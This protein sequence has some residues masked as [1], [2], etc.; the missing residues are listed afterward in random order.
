MA[1]AVPSLDAKGPCGQPAFGGSASKHFFRKLA[2]G[3][4]QRRFDVLLHRQ[5]ADLRQQHSGQDRPAV[6]A[7][8][9][10]HGMSPLGAIDTATLSY[11]GQQN[12]LGENA[13]GLALDC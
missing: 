12:R 11:A 7:S 4:H 9:C 13:Q 3:C 8:G 2:D 1:R 10:R 6:A 5:K